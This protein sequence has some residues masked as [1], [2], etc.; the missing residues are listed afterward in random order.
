[1]GVIREAGAHAVPVTMAPS[2]NAV[3]SE[4]PSEVGIRFSERVDAKASTLEVLDGRGERVDH[5]DATVDRADSWRYRVG[6]HALTDGAYTVAWRV[7]SAD[8]GHVTSGAYVFAVGAGS[9]LGPAPPVTPE[10]P[11]FQPLARW[12]VVVGSAFLL[13]IPIVG[14]WLRHDLGGRAP[15]SSLAWLGGGMILVGGALG[16][17]LQA[18]D[19]AGERPMAEVLG[20]LLTTRSGALWLCRSVLLLGLAALWARSRAGAANHWR[21]VLALGL[22]TAVV[23]SGGLVTHSATTVEGRALA[24]GVEGVHLVAV[25]LWV[26]GLVG[27]ALMLRP[28]MATPT[29]PAATSALALAIPAFSQ[30]AIPAVGALG[31]SGLMLARQHLTAWDELVRTPYGRWL[32]AK[33]VVF[34][35]ML[36]L[37]GYHQQRVHRRLRDAVAGGRADGATLARFRRSLRTEAGLGLVALLFAA[38]LA[39][40]S[41]SHLAVP[42][43]DAAFHHERTLD[44]ARVRLDVTPLRPGPNTIQLTVTDAAGHPLADATGAL[45]QLV[46]T[47]RRHRSRDLLVDSNGPGDVRCGR[48]GPGDRGPLGRPPR[49]PARGGLRRQRPV[50]V[51]PGRP[52]KRGGHPHARPR[53]PAGC[54][55]R[56]EHR[57]HHAGHGRPLGGELAHAARHSTPGRRC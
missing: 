39:S 42:D 17:G 20:A 38:T 6:V 19:L 8:D 24:L 5:G 35:A 56:M 43:A 34:A 12:L 54:G 14:F 48:C 7:L 44:D 10:G 45:V 3:L 50:R 30:L 47:A 13:G 52:A 37:A 46:P 16:L 57:G 28:G 27:F 40:T 11:G 4:A 21:R 15:G 1:M 23:I 53:P 49:R 33:L 25:A 22:A 9:A 32:T 31:L 2:A 29:A 36:A 18:W 41:P 26:G 55:H 51:D